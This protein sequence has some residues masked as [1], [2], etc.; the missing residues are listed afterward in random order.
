[1]KLT[2]GVTGKSTRARGG[3]GGSECEKSSG[4]KG[5]K[6]QFNCFV[7]RPKIRPRQHRHD[8]GILSA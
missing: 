8:G 5:G 7:E 6:H 1:M 3:K 4:G 2:T